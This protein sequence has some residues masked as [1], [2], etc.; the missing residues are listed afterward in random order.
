MCLLSFYCASRIGIVSFFETY[1]FFIPHQVLITH[2]FIYFY[3]LSLEFPMYFLSVYCNYM[4]P[5]D[6]LFFVILFI[7]FL[8]IS[9]FKQ[10]QQIPLEYFVFGIFIYI[11]FQLHL[12]QRK[13]FYSS[14]NHVHVDGTSVAIDKTAFENLNKIVKFFFEP[15]RVIIPGNL[16]IEG[17][18]RFPRPPSGLDL[19]PISVYQSYGILVPYVDYINDRLTYIHDSIHIGPY[20]KTYPWD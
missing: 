16:V 6:L 5:V 9:K 20:N 17:N 4:S 13:E 2:T 3:T 10:F 15:D 8:K 19:D 14:T 18:I 7:L 1:T 11:A 12:H